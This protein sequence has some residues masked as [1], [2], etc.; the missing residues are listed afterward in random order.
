MSTLGEYYVRISR[1]GWALFRQAENQA[2]DPTRGFVEALCRTTE[3][4]PVAIAATTEEARS[5]ASAM[6]GMLQRAREANP[7]VEIV[8]PLD[9]NHTDLYFD[10]DG[11]VD[12]GDFRDNDDA[13]PGTP[14][15]GARRDEAPSDHE[16]RTLVELLAKV[17]R[18]NR[19]GLSEREFVRLA[20]LAA[21]AQ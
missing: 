5:V 3:A 20:L 13:A 16:A 14:E 4:T 12:T 6:R 10:A 17:L 11:N 7:G 2:I 8:F 18:N 15:G 21:G 9:G 1:P 19:G